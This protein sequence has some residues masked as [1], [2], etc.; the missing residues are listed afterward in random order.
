MI[1]LRSD[2]IT[3]PTSE[4][5]KVIAEAEVGDDVFG[6]DPA[7]NALQE[8][9]AAMFGFE[10]GLFV[11]SGTM[12][13][14]LCINLLTAPGGEV[15]IDES[16]HIFNYESTAAAHLSSVHLRPL[17]G[18]R[19]KLSAAMLRHRVR[20][21]NKWE[22]Q[23][24]VVAVENSTNK[25]GGACYSNAELTDIYSFADEHKLSVHLDGARIWNAMTATGTDP[26]FYGSVCDT[27][28]VCFSKGLGAPVGSMMLSSDARIRR[29]RRMRKMW[30]GGMRQVGV[31]AAAANYAIENHLS[32]LDA[33]HRRARELAETIEECPQLSMD[34]DTVE[35]N[36]LIFDVKEDTAEEAVAKLNKQGVQVVAF[37][38]QTLRATFHLEIN[39]AAIERAKQVFKAC[40][41]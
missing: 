25:G 10:A 1:D 19:G 30:G 17:S 24:Q 6:E 18:Q 14:Q 33:D 15:L 2:T 8:K 20:G 11:P 12:S 28:S 9:V 5:R 32:L 26:Q 4:M 35:T 27:M 37:G 23:T 13:N 16:G 29:A 22:P 34:V 21:A 40:F 41:G 38:P 3:K 39:D 36:I 7:V 31:L